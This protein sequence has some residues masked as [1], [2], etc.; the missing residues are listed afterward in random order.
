MRFLIVGADSV[1]G[2]AFARLAR[3]L[4]NTTYETT[5][6]PD[7][8]DANR[9]YLDLA[10]D[11]V[12][13]VELPKVDVAFFCAAVSGFAR[14]R[15]DPVLAR[16]VNVEGT[17]ITAHQLV[18]NGAYVVLLSSTAVFDFQT[19]QVAPDA[20]TR[21]RTLHGQIKAA[22]ERVFLDP[23]FEGSVLRLTKVFTPDTGLIPS[24]INALRQG[25]R[26]TAFSDLHIAPISLD[27]ATG[28]MLAVA[29]DRGR[30]VYQMSGAKDV[31]YFDV[32]IHL[33]RAMGCPIELVQEKRAQDMGVPAE[34]IARYTTLDGSRLMRLT[35]R[36]APE[37]YEVIDR[38]Y[39]AQIKLGT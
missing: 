2:A 17:S 36:P 9:L 18:A 23:S 20:P 22:A 35:H 11:D 28:A 14:C 8:A 24:W 39:A 4:G 12:G 16:R 3:Q 1:T 10:S 19:P 6:R 33:A 25:E 26:I 38:V 5:R 31:S 32:A 15:A 13:R 27:D 29:K 34:D 21:S 37:P 7:T 30:G